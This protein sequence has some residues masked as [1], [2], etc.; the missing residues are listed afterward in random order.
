MAGCYDD[1]IGHSLDSQSEPLFKNRDMRNSAFGDKQNNNSETAFVLKW[2]Y[3]MLASRPAAPLKSCAVELL[4]IQINIPKL[5]YILTHFQRETVNRIIWCTIDVMPTESGL[6]VGFSF[7]FKWVFPHL[8]TAGSEVFLT[9][10]R[11]CKN[12]TIISD[13]LLF[14]IMLNIYIIF[15]YMLCVHVY[16]H[17]SGHW[18]RMG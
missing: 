17:V 11:S 7:F 18:C 15:T 5:Q 8:Q 6:E 3:V 10:M 12:S 4:F 9:K 13:I 2:L 1:I 14:T 16:V